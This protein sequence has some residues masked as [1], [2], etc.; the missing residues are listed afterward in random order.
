MVKQSLLVCCYVEHRKF[1]I[2]AQLQWTLSKIMNSFPDLLPPSHP[3][4]EHNHHIKALIFAQTI[5]Y[6][7]KKSDDG[8]NSAAVQEGYLGIPERI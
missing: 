5:W 3:S 8:I 4:L 2:P 6:L 7:I 1:S